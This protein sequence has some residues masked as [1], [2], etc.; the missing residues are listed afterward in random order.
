MMKVSVIK[1]LLLKRSGWVYWD[2]KLFFEDKV[3]LPVIVAG[4]FY[5]YYGSSGIHLGYWWHAREM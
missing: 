2:P 1:R 4:K 5:G 3:P